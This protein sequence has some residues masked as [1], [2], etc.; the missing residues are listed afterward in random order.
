MDTNNLNLLGMIG[1]IGA[2]MMVC[3]TFMT[4]I[5]NP[6]YISGWDFFTTWTEIL[7]IKNTFLPFLDVISGIAIFELMILPTFCNKDPFKRLN[8][9]FGLT[10][11][12]LAAALLILSALF[13][14]KEITVIIF[15]I[16]IIDYLDIGFWTTFAGTVAVLIGGFMP[17]AKNWGRDSI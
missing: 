2:I 7:K 4:W 10:T 14:V 3:G 8:T 9:I 11:A 6:L 13:M 1:L 15:P 5:G 16:Q 17:L 12:L